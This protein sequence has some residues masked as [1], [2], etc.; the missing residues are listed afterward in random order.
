MAVGVVVAARAV[1]VVGV[2]V[3]D[4][5]LGWGA[6]VVDRGAAGNFNL[7]GGVVDAEV[8]AELVVDA[9]Q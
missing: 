4:F 6:A 9:F 5:G 3:D 8:V 2:A 7:D 1:A